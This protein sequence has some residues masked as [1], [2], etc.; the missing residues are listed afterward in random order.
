MNN[1]KIEKILKNIGTEKVPDYIKRIA[2]ETS[3]DFSKKLSLSQKSK[4]YILLEFIM[5]SKLTKLAAAAVIIISVFFRL[6]FSGGSI[7]LTNVAFADMTEAMKTQ[8]WVHIKSGFFS[9]NAAGP[10]EMWISFGSKIAA[11]KMT[12][13][14]TT[15][16]NLNEHKS[17][18][19]DP[20]SQSIT[21]DYVYENEFP[22]YFSSPAS[23]IESMNEQLEAQGAQTT[24]SV[25][26]SFYLICTNLCMH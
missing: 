9:A 21:I 4:R 10:K 7:S 20:N 25:T 11:A 15:V 19:Y 2:R 17:Y 22:E 5:K 23:I 16:I 8:S 18:T 6:H 3:D 12:S 24:T 13:G 14:Q 1:E 26:L